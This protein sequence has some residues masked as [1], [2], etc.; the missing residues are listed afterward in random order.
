MDETAKQQQP[1]AYEAT[2]LP[3]ALIGLSALE[4]KTSENVATEGFVIRGEAECD[5]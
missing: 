1:V 4:S 5:S 2:L 3:V